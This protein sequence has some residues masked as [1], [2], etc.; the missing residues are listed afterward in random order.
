MIDNPQP[1]LISK[2][3]KKIIYFSSSTQIPYVWSCNRLLPCRLLLE[4]F[5]HSS[6]NIR[7]KCVMIYNFSKFMLKLHGLCEK[8]AT[9]NNINLLKQILKKIQRH[10]FKLHFISHILFFTPRI[11]LR[12]DFHKI[13]FIGAQLNRP[14]QHHQVRPSGITHYMDFI[15][16]PMNLNSKLCGT[17][18]RSYH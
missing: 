14:N 8:N 9:L 16:S 10:Q 2:R 12:E 1:N 4:G 3:S 7:E 18:Q 17:K 11:R 15:C 5:V 6:G 13:C